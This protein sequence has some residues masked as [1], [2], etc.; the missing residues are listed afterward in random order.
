MSTNIPQDILKIFQTPQICGK[1]RS[2]IV[3]KF[4]QYKVQGFNLIEK[5]RFEFLKDSL[6]LTLV[7]QVPFHT[8]VNLV[9]NLPKEV[10]F[11]SL[12]GTLLEN[13][14]FPVHGEV[15]QAQF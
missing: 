15:V 11:E 1:F 13:Y 12:K 6:P 14:A 10:V 2:E 9:L 3:Q 7:I 8:K 5:K 4:R